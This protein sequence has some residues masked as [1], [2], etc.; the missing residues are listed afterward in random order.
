MTKF[1]SGRQKNLKIGITSYSENTQ[2]LEVIGRVGIGSTVFS[3]SYD[4]DVRGT[5]RFS[6]NVT[7]GANLYPDTDGLYD[8][9]R[10]PQ[11]GLGANRWKD[12]N[13]LG[14]GTFGTGVSAH[15]IEL[16]VN[17]ANLIY[18]TSGNLE[19]NSQSGI[20]NIDDIVTISGNLGIGT[21]NPTSK[22][23]V[24]GA[25]NFIGTVTATEFYGSG[26][27][28]TGLI[29]N[30]IVDVSND[31]L[32]YPMLSPVTSGTIPNFSVSSDSI[33]FNPAQNALG[34]GTTSLFTGANTGSLTISG[35]VVI[36]NSVTNPNISNVL[37]ASNSSGVA[38]YRS[39]NLI[40]TSSVIK[41]VR[42]STISAGPAF[43]LQHWSTDL[44]ENYG[45]WDFILENGHFALRD[46][47]STVNKT[48]FFVSRFGNFLIGANSSNIGINS[49]QS[50]GYGTDNILQ[51]NGNS[52]LGGY[53]G[54]GTTTPT[55]KLWVDGDGYFTGVVTATT[56]I[57]NLSGT[58][59]TANNLSNAANITTGTIDKDRLLNS[60]SFSVLGDLYVSNNISF[61]GTTTQLNLQQLQIVDA[62]IVLGIGTSFSPTDNTANH[63]GI[64]I[65][66]TEGSPLVNLNIVPEET[67]PSTYKKIMWF[68][69]SS[70]GAG[71]T[72]AWLFNYA[73][74]VGS[75]R[76]PNG[77]R[78]AAGGMQVTDTTISTPN[79]NVSG[80]GTFQS[81]GLKI[82]NPANTFGYTIA[83]GA[84]AADYTLTLPVV[85]ANTGIALTGITQTFTA[86][87]TYS[88]GLTVSSGTLTVSGGTITA[89]NNAATLL[90]G[91]TTTNITLGTSLTSGT[92]IIGNNIQTGTLTLGT[93]IVS[94]TLNIQAGVS[95]VGTTK[96]INF[97]TG[98][99]SGSFTQ[100]N[101]GPTA[102]VG[103]VTINSGTNL[104][105]GTTTPTSALTVV[106]NVL[107]SGISTL[108]VTTTTNLTAQQLN[109]SGITT[110]GF[111]TATNISVSGIVTSNEYYI[112]TTQVISSA[113]QLQNIASLDAT[114][115]ATIETAIQQAPNDFTS[116]NISGISTL[117]STTLIGG[118]TSTGTAGQVLQ[119]TGI[120]SS[121]YIGGDLGIGTTLPTSKL[122]V[123][124]NVLVSGVSTFIGGG[125]SANPSVYARRNDN[126]DAGIK[127]YG[128]SGGNW[129]YSESTSS[130]VKPLIIDSSQSEN[131]LFRIAGGTKAVIQ[132][133]GELL[134]GSATSTG[135]ADQL[136][137][138]NSGAY[139]FGNLGIGITNT[140][141][142]LEVIGG[143][144][145][146]A[147]SSQGDIQITHANL[148]S[149]I[150]GGT[151]T[152][153]ALG[154]NGAEVVR[155]NSTGVGIGTTNPTSTL[156]VFGGGTSAG[157]ELNLAVTSS[158]ANT[159]P[160][161]ITTTDSNGTLQI[162]GGGMS[163]GSRRGGQIDFV[164]GAATTNPGSLIFRTGIATGGTSQPEVARF[165]SSGNLGIGTTNPTS[166]LH[167]V[168][169]AYVSE[170]L[171]I[172]TTN[173][174]SALDVRGAITVGVG[175]VGINSISSTTDIQSWYYTEKSIPSGNTAPQGVYVGAAGTSMYVVGNTGNVI[176]QYP[177]TISYDV[178]TA[179]APV[180]VCT[181]ST[182]ED[183]PTGIDFHP[184]GTKM[185]VCG[186]SG[187]GIFTDAV[188]EYSLSTPWN[189]ASSSIGYTTSYNV[190]GQEGT[191]T[192][193]VIGAAGTAM[194]VVGD[195]SRTVHQYTLTTPYSIADGNV[196][197]TS[198][199]LVLSVTL[200]ST[201]LETSPQDISFNSTGTVLWVLGATNNRIYEFRLGTAW[202]I[203]TAV[204]H[205]DVYVGFNEPNPLGLHVIP[206]QNVAYVC[207]SASSGDRVFQYS[208][209]TPALEIASS[210]ISSASSIILNNE[211]RVK[212]KLYVKGNTHVDG[213]ILTQGTLTVGS[214][215]TV[216]STLTA[217]ATVTF[218]T[219]TSNINL[220]TSQTTGALI[221]GGTLQTGSIT[222][223]R[224]TTSQT[225]NIQAGASGVGTTKTINFGTGGLSGSF[226]QINIGP[227][228]GVG[229]VVINSGTNL[230]VGT[231][232]ATGT[233]SQ[234]LQVNSGAY[235]SDN[236]GIGTTNPTSKL[237]V[238]G[239]TYIS[240]ILTATDINS[241]SDIRLKTNIKP[242]EN[243][244]EK[245]VQ[246]NGVSFNWIDSNAKSGGIIAQDVEKVFPELVND[247][248]HKT[249]NYNGLIGVL[250]ESIK[251]LKQEVE[252]LKSRLG[253]I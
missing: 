128:T 182:Q 162:F 164:A 9:G 81:S 167:V 6:G 73:V 20:T 30:E 27:G 135:T 235:V 133:S 100:I 158:N 228:A 22:L 65:A 76:V 118:G 89:G 33:V 78:L 62:D 214:T 17:S 47:T 130:N 249:V 236:L 77:V 52:Y 98:G 141:N 225:T 230:L 203:S 109:V 181:V 72:D 132:P 110:V 117:Q 222:L 55:S 19:L 220:G 16:G 28:L 204:F 192:G 151:T 80:V 3:A 184:N 200:P 243:T 238:V 71:I 23:S 51:V 95:G 145:R 185:F 219:D 121:A 206:E 138:V 247:G 11:I 1:L 44:T 91:N 35:K 215:A 196:T 140:S 45:Y 5:S 74:G 229:T 113:R 221:L 178:S 115:T 187:V 234:R 26:I 170:N 209:N 41:V 239:D 123:D 129:V 150:K 75:T 59:T 131:I 106:G 195:T 122:H 244:L 108:G 15:D 10:A 4:L 169:G 193:V 168:G 70:I 50:V 159:I 152:Q 87:Q 227:T 38:A 79:L 69:G 172:G 18:S 165:S 96:T 252:D 93:A 177:L 241:A 139:V 99:G 37:N 105:I 205:D 218:G 237:H 191:P 217:G 136:L 197:Y 49:I 13:F 157:G 112:G 163:S 224:A 111:L 213:N 240:G 180:G 97:G 202:D 88:A 82:R 146:F 34:I 8:V 198:K 137:Q 250:I 14:K 126:N 127:L 248:D 148:V 84:I 143:D 57:G 245:I 242:F 21:T 54:I 207:G 12:A 40:D 120:S 114:T 173:P 60:N 64:A 186:Q 66:S 211:T 174:Q 63:G 188:H 144:V 58:A 67:N 94:Q 36:G 232:T 102:G 147:T 226:T 253:E 42:L 53:V 190:G 210:G 46:R 166:K 86:L 107:V 85:T 216:S 24:V 246:I 142:K 154:G 179:G 171:G 155:I 176:T 231:T 101:I 194:Y 201:I 183:T 61:G 29:S 251:E 125:T 124:G 119:V 32:Y 208:T 104:G 43:E 92:L 212:D 68:K 189:I 199:T 25:G 149:T 31:Q 160:A 134:V 161:T 83:G 7:L 2:V 39:F 153:L 103:T 116:L 90:S 56:F 223:G 175:T 233:A 48:R 156:H